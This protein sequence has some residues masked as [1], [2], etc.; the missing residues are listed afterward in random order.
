[1]ATAARRGSSPRITPPA[2]TSTGARVASRAG[3]EEG[4][5]ICTASVKKPML[6]WHLYMH[7][8]GV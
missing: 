5:L 3:S 8:T 4:F 7:G 1:M 2:S 6:R